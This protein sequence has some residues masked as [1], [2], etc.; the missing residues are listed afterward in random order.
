MGG[1]QRAVCRLRDTPFATTRSSTDC[2][3]DYVRTLFQADDGVL[4]VGTSRGL[5]R[6]VDVLQCVLTRADG[7]PATPS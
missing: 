1:H 4:W 7:Y 6:Y 2:P 5:N 3:D